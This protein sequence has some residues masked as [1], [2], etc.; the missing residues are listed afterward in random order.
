M[1]GNFYGK[2]KS[3]KGN[4]SFHPIEANFF[5]LASSNANECIKLL[6]VLYDCIKLDPELKYSYL[7]HFAD[8][9]TRKFAY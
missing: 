8:V 9:A 7:L 6:T 2:R 5:L 3:T 4:I 1:F